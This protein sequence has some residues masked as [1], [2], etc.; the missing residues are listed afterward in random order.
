MADSPRAD[1]AP[2]SPTPYRPVSG[3]AV[4]GF[5]VALLAALIIG[6]MAA[7]SLWTGKPALSVAGLIFAAIGFALSL[8]GFLRVRA[9]EG[10]RAGLGLAQAGLA[11]SALFGL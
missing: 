10:T 3:L 6:G 11:L 9:S 7:A 5:G 8:A 1:S 4:A 2:I